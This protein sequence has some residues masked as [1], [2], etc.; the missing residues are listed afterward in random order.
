[1]VFSHDQGCP[2]GSH[3][4]EPVRVL[5]QAPPK[6]LTS[7]LAV[8]SKPASSGSSVAPGAL[9]GRLRQFPLDAQGI[10]MRYVRRGYAA[11]VAYY[12]VPAAHIGFVGV[13]GRC[14]DQEAAAFKAQ[15]EH[16]PTTSRSSALRWERRR[17]NIDKA[18]GPPGVALLTDGGGDYGR[19]YTVGELRRRP[20]G[21][22][23]GGNDSVT[24][25]ALVV[26]NQVASVTARYSP[27]KGPGRVALPVAVTRPAVNNV[28]IFV[29]R[30]AWDTPA[31]TFRSSSGSVLSTERS[32]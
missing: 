23:S 13:P 17:I 4:L 18:G 15:I 32:P 26:P 30:G 21:G 22:G 5:D 10:Y 11:G 29:F 20:Y 14:F 1:M 19:N 8:L 7:V 9:R 3:S 16:L 31:L 2:G 12:L 6:D 27:Q 24:E 25:T 28:V